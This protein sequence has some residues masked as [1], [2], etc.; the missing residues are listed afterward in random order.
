[1]ATAKIE[2]KEVSVITT[3]TKEV[4]VLTLELSVEEVKAIYTILRKIGG[5]PDTS[6]RKYIDSVYAALEP[7]V[8]VTHT[9]PITCRDW[10]MMFETI[11]ENH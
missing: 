1:M 9:Y 6:A 7:H 5:S 10:G 4:Q 8:N 2:T 11:T 3:T